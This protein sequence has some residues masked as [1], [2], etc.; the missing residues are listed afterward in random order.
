[1]LSPLQTGPADGLHARNAT[2]HAR[3][4]PTLNLDV[5]SETVQVNLQFQFQF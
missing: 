3:H 2:L 1:M 5:T 4:P